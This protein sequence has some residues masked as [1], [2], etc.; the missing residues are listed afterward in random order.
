MTKSDGDGTGYDIGPQG[1]KKRFE[2]FFFPELY[3]KTAVSRIKKLRGV[4]G[5]FS[6]MEGEKG[7][8]VARQFFCLAK[9]VAWKP[10]TIWHTSCKK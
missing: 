1:E 7:N 3:G 8:F 6:K 4:C 10:N 9:K 5:R 2:S